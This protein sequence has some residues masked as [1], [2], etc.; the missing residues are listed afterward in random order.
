MKIIYY[1]NKPDMN[2][3]KYK[4]TENKNI[5]DQKDKKDVPY[6]VSANYDE[7]Y[8][9]ID[10]RKIII[11][12][13]LIRGF[14]IRKIIIIPSS[15]YQTKQWRKSRKWYRNGKH[16]ECE[17]YQ[18]KI[19]EKILCNNLEKTNERINIEI[20]E[21]SIMNNPNR[22][23]NGYEWTEN[24]DGKIKKCNKLFYFNLNFVCD[25]GGSQN[26]TLREVYHFIKHQLN[27]LLNFK[28]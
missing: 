14:L 10:I 18:K 12:Q 13:K 11:I 8:N 27:Y 17:I 15:F 9:D 28:N 25:K 21:I 19:V 7:K 6:D 5:L 26:R 16:N 24:F 1:R 4:N 2:S 23:K 20:G 22:N 3:T